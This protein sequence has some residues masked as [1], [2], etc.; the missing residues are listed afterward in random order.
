MASGH[1][2]KTPTDDPLV[3]PQVPLPPKS[4][5]PPEVSLAD[6]MILL[7]QSNK[8]LDRSTEENKRNMEENKKMHEKLG[9]S[10]KEVKVCLN[11]QSNEVQQKTKMAEKRIDM[12]ETVQQSASTEIDEIKSTVKNLQN[13]SLSTSNFQPPLNLTNLLNN[14]SIF[15]SSIFSPER[16]NDAVHQFTGIRNDIHPEKFLSELE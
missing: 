5:N 1:S 9:T 2:S 14:P 3:G 4:R 6:L 10:L 15:N 16:L 8:K 11:T 13:V 7:K 12:L